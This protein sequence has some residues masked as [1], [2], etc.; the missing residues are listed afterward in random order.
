MDKAI[1]RATVF[2]NTCGFKKKKKGLEKIGDTV[3]DYKK[4]RREKEMV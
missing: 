3:M 2:L 1:Q 4:E